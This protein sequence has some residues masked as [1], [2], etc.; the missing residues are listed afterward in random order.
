[1]MRKINQISNGV[2]FIPQ[3]KPIYGQEE[4]RAVSDYLKTPDKSWLIEYQYTKKFEKMLAEFTGARYCSLL[5][6]GT[7]TLFT[8]LKA[9]G[10]GPNDE[11]IVPDIT[12]AATPNA[13]FLAGAKVVFVDIEPKSLCLDVE[14]T[15]KAITKRTKAVMH[16]S[17]NG[18]SGNLPELKKLCR[19]KKIHLIEDAAQ[20][21]G[22]YCQGKHLGRHGILGSF[23]FSMAKIVTSG[24][25]G[26]LITDNPKIFKEI[27]YIKDFGRRKKGEDFWKKMGWNFKYTDFQAV[28]GIEQMK[29]LRTRMRL[30]KKIFRLY[31]KLLFDVPAVKFVETDLKEV[32]PWV[33]DVLVPRREKLIDFLKKNNIGSHAGYPA[34]HSQPAYALRASAGKPAYAVA[35]KAAR[36]VLWLPSFVTLTEKQIQYICSKIKSFYAR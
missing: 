29:K 17:L 8:A 23:S 22:S 5:S 19:K 11:V 18:R 14:K 15:K 33:M 1:M 27:K 34:L 6:N 36:E 4:I 30:K 3:I 20:S 25:G 31:Q 13:V 7:L 26:A 10:V 9:L 28:F 2:K 35:E 32:T 24:Q 16:V 21:L 12:M